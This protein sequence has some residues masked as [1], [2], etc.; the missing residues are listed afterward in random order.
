MFPTLCF[1]NKKFV[2]LFSSPHDPSTSSEFFRTFFRLLLFCCGKLGMRQRISVA[3]WLLSDINFLFALPKIQLIS[4]SLAQKFQ[5]CLLYVPRTKLIWKGKFSCKSQSM[6]V[7]YMRC[8]ERKNK[9]C[10][11]TWKLC[12][13]SSFPHLALAYMLTKVPQDAN[14][15]SF[16]M[17]LVWGL[18][19]FFPKKFSAKGSKFKMR[20]KVSL[21]NLY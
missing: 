8:V 20:W 3:S 17:W 15:F 14:K 9:N 5:L 16:F 6:A 12:N 11:L 10:A 18:W 2:D 13:P 1:I 4:H 21:L 7:N 19:G